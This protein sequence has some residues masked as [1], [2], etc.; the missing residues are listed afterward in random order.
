MLLAASPAAADVNNPRFFDYRSGSFGT[1]IL[2]LTFG[3]FKTLDADQKSAYGQALT[4]AIMFA[5]N[6]QKVEWYRNNASGIVMPAMTWP[7]GSGYCRRIH[8]Q[9][10]AHNTERTMARS[11]CFSN[12][13]GEWHWVRE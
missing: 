2:N 13:S 10:V 5:E 1:E 8:I 9:A 11:V 3:W 7:T 6:G 12:A 4:H